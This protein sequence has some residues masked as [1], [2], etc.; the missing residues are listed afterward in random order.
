MCVCSLES[1]GFNEPQKQPVFEVLRGYKILEKGP[2][3]STFKEAIKKCC[4]IRKE[5]LENSSQNAFSNPRD[6]HDWDVDDS[7]YE[8]DVHIVDNVQSCN[9]TVPTWEEATE[10]NTYYEVCDNKKIG[11]YYSYT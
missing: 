6:W 10:D 2:L 7:H 4:A 9:D 8:S 1:D 5:Y 3:D 11:C